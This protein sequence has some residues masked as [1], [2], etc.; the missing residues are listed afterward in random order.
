M[1]SNSCIE[2]KGRGW[3]VGEC[4]PRETCGVCDGAGEIV[5]ALDL[6]PGYVIGFDRGVGRDEG[7]FLRRFVCHGYA[8]LAGHHCPDCGVRVPL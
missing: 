2:C 4:H 1:K 3:H 8:I 5:A 7:V 6:D